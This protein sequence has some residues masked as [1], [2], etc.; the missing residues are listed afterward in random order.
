LVE[1][2]FYPQSTNSET[3]EGTGFNLESTLKAIQG[4][5]AIAQQLLQLL[6]SNAGN[7]VKVA[8]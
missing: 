5:T 1:T 6:L 8:Q 7:A 2:S 4:N 3:V